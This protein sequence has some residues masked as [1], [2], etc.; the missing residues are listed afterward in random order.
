M[1]A[2]SRSKGGVAAS[3]TKF[4]ASFLTRTE[5]HLCCF[6]VVCV[7]RYPFPRVH[8]DVAVSLKFLA[9]IVHRAQVGVLGRR[10]FAVE[11]A[12]AHLP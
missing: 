6:S 9:I 10:G 7:S 8:A 11:S 3:Q 5:S 4:D 1:A 2:R 12:V